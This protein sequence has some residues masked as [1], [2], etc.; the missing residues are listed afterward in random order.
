MGLLKAEALKEH[1]VHPRN[2]GGIP[3]ANRLVEGRNIHSNMKTSQRPSNRRNIH[4][5][6]VE[7]IAGT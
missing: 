2:G 4:D 6:L 3:I 5:G 7:E 1:V